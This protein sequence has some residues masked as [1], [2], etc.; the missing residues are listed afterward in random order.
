MRSIDLSHSGCEG[1]DDETMEQKS[2]SDETDE[3][4]RGKDV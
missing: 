1:A 4:T 3:V 2:V